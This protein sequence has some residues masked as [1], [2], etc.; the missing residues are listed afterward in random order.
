MATSASIASPDTRFRTASA[1]RRILVVDDHADTRNLL[2]VDLHAHADLFRQLCERQQFLEIGMA[3]TN[4][5]FL[6]GGHLHDL[7]DFGQHFAVVAA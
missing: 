2:C 5:D 3:E 1:G 4:A 7:F 6:C